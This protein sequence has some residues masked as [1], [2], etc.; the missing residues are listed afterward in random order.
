MMSVTTAAMDTPIHK[1]L[2]VFEENVR[3]QKLERKKSLVR[4]E[5]GRMYRSCHPKRLPFVRPDESIKL[6]SIF[7][8]APTVIVAMMTM[9]C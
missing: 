2:S 1:S 8:S 5:T 3:I 4:I 6:L 7:V 9:L